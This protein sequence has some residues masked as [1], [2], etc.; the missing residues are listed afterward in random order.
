M[1]GIMRNTAK[2]EAEGSC[3]ILASRVLK[4]VDR[5]LTGISVTTNGNFLYFSYSFEENSG[6][7]PRL[8]QDRFLPNHFRFISLPAVRHCVA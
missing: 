7:I 6:L 3:E 5:I 1:V 2:M 4:G 8:F